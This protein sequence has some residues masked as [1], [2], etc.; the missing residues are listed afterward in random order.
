MIFY[1]LIWP[2]LCGGC[3]CCCYC[4]C[5]LRLLWFDTHRSIKE[6][7]KQ[8]RASRS[9]H[10]QAAAVPHTHTPLLR[11]SIHNPIAPLSCSLPLPPSLSHASRLPLPVTFLYYYLLLFACFSRDRMK[12]KLYHKIP[13]EKK[14]SKMNS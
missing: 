13:T 12:Q 7:D 2:Y 9:K 14:Y 8:A 10:G 4:C 3:C 6:G 5:S 1:F 11:K